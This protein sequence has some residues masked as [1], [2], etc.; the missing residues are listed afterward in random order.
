M[1]KDALVPFD[2]AVDPYMPPAFA[3]KLSVFSRRRK[4]VTIPTPDEFTALN[5]AHV[6]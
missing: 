1:R 4:T 5:I 3:T 2:P 6:G